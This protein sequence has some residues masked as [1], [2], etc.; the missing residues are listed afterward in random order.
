M[1]PDE[2]TPRQSGESRRRSRSPPDSNGQREAPRRGLK[3]RG[4]FHDL[5]PSY[6]K[7]LREESS[8]FNAELEAE[9]AR[10]RALSPE[11]RLKEDGD[12]LRQKIETDAEMVVSLEISRSLRARCRANDCVGLRADS[13][14]DSDS[15]GNTITTEYRICVNGVSSLEWY[16]RTKHYYHV[17]C[18]SSMIDLKDLLPSKLKMDGSSGRWG[19]MVEKWFEHT[20]RID[21]DKIAEFL[22]ELAVYEAKHGD[23]SSEYIEWSLNHGRNCKDKELECKCPARPQPLEKPKLEDYRT[24]DGDT[25]TLLDVLEHP[26]VDKMVDRPWIPTAFPSW[27]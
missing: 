26:L 11:E 16:G 4:I 6:F 3:R 7:K 25:C 15:S 18:F 24:E 20:G 8:K 27:S 1:D 14:S 10:R 22:E 5:S 21:L 17:A 9:D 13:D 19:L 23:W 2:P 12:K